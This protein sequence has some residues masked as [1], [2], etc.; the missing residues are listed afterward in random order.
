M[1]IDTIFFKQDP[2][3]T[4]KA[5][6][7]KEINHKYARRKLIQFVRLKNKIVEDTIGIKY[8]TKEDIQDI[9]KWSKKVCENIYDDLIIMVASGNWG[10]TAGTC[11]WCIKNLNDSCL[12]CEYG[13][14]HGICGQKNAL[15]SEYAIPKVKK[16]LTGETYEEMI[17][18]IE[19]N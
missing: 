5:L 7:I 14:R 19:N 9:T 2:I 1:L 10:F 6:G 17:R 12:R 15:Y 18:K 16:R 11:I 4:A 3:T 8:A 13:N